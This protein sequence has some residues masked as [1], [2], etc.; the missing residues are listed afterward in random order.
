MTVF[1]QFLLNLRLC[2]IISAQLL[3]WRTFCG[4]TLARLKYT[5]GQEK[6]SAVVGGVVVAQASQV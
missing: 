2:H 6:F 4:P 1:K 3:G 5:G